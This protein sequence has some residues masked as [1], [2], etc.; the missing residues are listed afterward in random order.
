MGINVTQQKTGVKIWIPITAAVAHKIENWPRDNEVILTRSSGKPWK[1]R[2][3]L[4]SRWEYERNHNPR[5]AICSDLVLHGLRASSC[6]R[7]RRAGA[8]VLQISDM[9]GLSPKM[10]GRYCRLAD[11][12]LNALAAV[13]LIDRA[14][15]ERSSTKI[16]PS[17]DVDQPIEN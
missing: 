16:K 11:Q 1:N 5:L 8:T 6:I 7:L 17:K 12:Q 9:I 14:D 15:R 2:K 13:E 10:V 4:A 3:E